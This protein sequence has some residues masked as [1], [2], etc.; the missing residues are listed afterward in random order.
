[1]ACIILKHVGDFGMNLLFRFGMLFITL[2]PG[3]TY[4][5][6]DYPDHRGS[7]EWGFDVIAKP[8]D[9]YVVNDADGGTIDRYMFRQ[10]GEI[11][12]NVPIR[13]YVG[14]TD[15]SGHLQ[16]ISTLVSQG[17]VSETFN[18]YMPAYDVDEGVF[19]VFDCDG[20]G[21]NDQLYDEV[22]E[23]YLN[24]EKIGKFRGANRRWFQQTYT[25]ETS[26]LKFPSAPG[27]VATNEIRVKID[28]DNE[29]V[30]LSSGRVGC[31]VWATEVDWVGIQFKA[32][33]PIVLVHGMDSTGSSLGNLKTGFTDRNLLADN[34][35]NFPIQAPPSEFSYGC[36]SEPYND[37]IAFNV[38][39]LKTE[40]PRIIKEYGASSVNL[41][42]H[43]KGG[44]DS[45]GFISSTQ[46]DN[47]IKVQVGTMSGQPVM[48]SLD[49]N[50]LVTVNTPHK[51]SIL[52]Q[53][54]VLARHITWLSAASSSDAALLLGVKFIEGS[55][56]CDLTPARASAF[57]STA[58][59][60][61]NIDTASV[62]TNADSN[63]NRT[64]D[65]AEGD[66]YPVGTLFTSLSHTVVGVVGS[67]QI[68]IIPS[69][70]W[71][72]PDDVI[73]TIGANTQFMTNDINVTQDS[74]ARYAR[75]PS[76]DNLNHLNVHNL[77][78]AETI[79]ADAQS[80][81]GL[82]NWRAK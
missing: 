29:T 53:Y 47:E 41:V 49:V 21:V 19:P 56:Y 52:A 57:V 16:N 18:I 64:I 43:S 39:H 40:I 5:G 17:V 11:V 33:A 1:L 71:Y 68:G 15:G 51:G 26:K 9:V 10:D 13:R 36:G 31:T 24:D 62:A 69:G 76:I 74:A 58:V 72:V 77:S 8:S 2:L 81:S 65:G 38:N 60:P 55:W 27:G 37:S 22:N 61:G 79:A 44:L 14:P 34:S 23:V 46:G 82:V 75:Y 28:V 50:S 63:R 78:T 12:I 45:L 73:I 42:A 80:E 35:I 6:E 67:V 48:H 20:D 4:A 70:N 66:G 25:I 30:V 7:S 3:I 54:G 32:A 59:L